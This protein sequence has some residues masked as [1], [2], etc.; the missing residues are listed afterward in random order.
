MATVEVKKLKEQKSTRKERSSFK[1]IAGKNASGNN[2]VF[3]QNV[4]L[5]DCPLKSRTRG[6]SAK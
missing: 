5:S 1:E 6:K 2:E 3:A 4:D